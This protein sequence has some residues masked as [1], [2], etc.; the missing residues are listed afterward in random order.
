MKN[1][2]YLLR[3]ELSQDDLTNIYVAIEANPCEA[4]SFNFVFSKLL[5]KE[6]ITKDLIP[7]G[8]I[9]E[10]IGFN[11]LAGKLKERVEKFMKFDEDEF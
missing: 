5:E 7:L 2:I 9:V 11:V 10:A 1:L 6:E 4:V 3:S 8:R